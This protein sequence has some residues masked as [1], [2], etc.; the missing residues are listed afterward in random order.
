[1][2]I[3]LILFVLPAERMTCQRKFCHRMIVSFQ[4]DRLSLTYFVNYIY[5]I[6][7]IFDTETI[8]CQYISITFG[9]ELRKTLTKFEFTTIDVYGTECSF[10]ALYGIRWK[11][12]GIDTE[13]ITNSCTF[14]FDISWKCTPILGAIPPLW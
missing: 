1:M 8:A 13:D 6:A 11:Q 12:I 2:F 5:S 4:S 7:S 3:V 14:E 9:M 10:F